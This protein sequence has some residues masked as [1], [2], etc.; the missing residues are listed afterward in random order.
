MLMYCIAEISTAKQL[1]RAVSSV[2]HP[3]INPSGLRGDSDS[4]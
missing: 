4:L 3:V 1:A 2:I